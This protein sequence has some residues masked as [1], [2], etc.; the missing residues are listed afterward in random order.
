LI[1]LLLA[2]L[3]GPGW[4]GDGGA[5]P[6]APETAPTARGV[7]LLIGDDH[8]LE[9][10]AWGDPVAH[11]PNLDRLAA[12]GTRFT[13]AFATVSSCSS[14][15]SVLL[16][17]LH[18]HQNGQYGLA[19]AVHNQHTFEWVQTLPALLRKAG[20]RTGLVG[21]KHVKPDG[22]YRFDVEAAGPQLAGNRDVAAMA[23]A[24]GEFLRGSAGRGF[25]LVMGYSDPHREFQGRLTFP[26][27]PPVPAVDPARVAVPRFLPDLPEVRRELADYY[28]SV[29]RLDAGVGLVLEELRQ[30]GREGDTLVV[31]LSD[32]G[33]PFPGAKTNL[34]DAGIRLPL[35][36]ASP[37]VSRQGVVSR[38]MV[39]FVDLAPTVLEW[40]GAPGPSYPLTG[41]S[42]LPVLEREDPPGWDEVYASHQL[43]E[44]HMYYPM[45]AVRTRRHAYI[46]NLAPEREYPL[47]KD[48]L[49]SASW[50]AILARGVSHV[51]ARGLDVT[52][53]RPAEE[54]YDVERDPDQVRNR[55]ADPALAPVLAE[56]RRRLEA[57][58]DR[59]SDP[60]IVG[61]RPFPR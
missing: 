1:P 2:V 55:A 26:G 25:L 40:M 43:H 50:K 3:L 44:I 9:V 37:A 54:L 29:A 53:R 61:E 38:A 16:T 14:S 51:G 60:W 31:Y 57:F 12:R 30:A 58:A 18:T 48:I 36:V 21:K 24:A 6:A 22:L 23:A 17:G 19:H 56:M 32:N 45:R 49:D 4:A 35:I 27:V 34:Y 52:L 41:R 11:T 7:L 5:A 10:G 47:A 42:W 39:S 8:G 46:R 20:H 33:M 13:S 15:R 28:E 59:T